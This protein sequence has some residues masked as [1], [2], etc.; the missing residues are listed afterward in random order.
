MDKIKQTTKEQITG[1]VF[2]LGDVHGRFSRCM[3]IA[4]RLKI[5]D[6]TIIQVG[7]FG[8]GFI[9]DYALDNLN[10]FLES[11]NCDMFVIRGNHDDPQFF[12]NTNKIRPRITL[13]E[14]FS[15]L[16][17]NGERWMFAGG[18]ISVDRIHRKQSVSWWSDEIFDGAR[19]SHIN[20]KCDVL[21]THTA[22][23]V[24]HPP[25]ASFVLDYMKADPDLSSDLNTEQ[26]NIATFVKSVGPKKLFCGHF[27][28]SKM[29]YHDGVQYQ[30][31]DIN[32]LLKYEQTESNNNRSH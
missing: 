2:L 26:A 3:N 13:L 23:F 22:P 6:A 10:A 25:L 9:E 32:E 16:D 15:V 20:E 11:I 24:A 1:D 7:D 31:L 19:S 21:I 5:S 12:K 4:M 17:V 27:H 8:M 14:D 30:I 18:A 29:T 28:T